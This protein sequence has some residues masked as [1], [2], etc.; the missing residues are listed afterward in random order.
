MLLFANDVIKQMNH[1]YGYNR[2]VN[3]T[4]PRLAAE[5][6]T[7]LAD[8]VCHIN[9]VTFVGVTSPLTAFN[10]R[11]TLRTYSGNVCKALNMH[12]SAAYLQYGISLSGES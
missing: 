3:E 8:F 7:I 2:I 6:C 9:I 11:I 10:L 12:C 1:R 4:L 5:Y